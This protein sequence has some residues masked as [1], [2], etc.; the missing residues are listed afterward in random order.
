VSDD[1][2]RQA[3]QALTPQLQALNGNFRL[4]S[5]PLQRCQKLAEALSDTLCDHLR[6]PLTTE[7]RLQEIY[8]G[9]WEGKAWNDIPRHEIDAWAA[10]VAAYVPPGGESVRQLRER[11]LSWLNEIEASTESCIVVTHAGVIRVL[12]GVLNNLP[13]DKWSQLPIDFASL[14]AVP[15]QRKIA[16]YA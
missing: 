14:T 16:P 6:W 8:F 5:S 11:V 3:M 12:L 9:D 4:V 1:E 10:D 2:V 7:D 13:F 15:L